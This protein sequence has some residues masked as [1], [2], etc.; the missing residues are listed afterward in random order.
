[1]STSKATSVRTD[2]F[3]SSFSKDTTSCV[4]VR[5]DGDVVLMRD[6]KYDGPPADQPVIVIPAR[7][8]AEFLTIAARP[9][10]FGSEL[11]IP[12]TEIDSTTGTV[13]ARDAVGTELTYTFREW[14]AFTAGITA[15]EF[16]TVAA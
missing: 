12:T 8:W 2:W 16:T 9:I 5:F 3:K 1:M 10:G 4:E 13:I 14:N 11:G 15:G 7:H 6:S